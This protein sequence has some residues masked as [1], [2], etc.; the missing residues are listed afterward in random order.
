MR[1]TSNP[2]F[3]NLPTQ[4]GGYATFDRS[5]GG[6]M[7]GA[8]A[9]A[10][11]QSSHVDPS[12]AAQETGRPITVDD[13]VQRTAISGGLALVAGF[14]TMWSGLI[15]LA[16]PAFVVGIVVALIVIFKQK[17]SAPL[18]LTYSGAMGV[19]L[20]GISSM[21]PGVALQAVIGTAGVFFGM[22][23]VYKTGA[24]RVT[25]RFTKWMMGALIGVV[26]LMLANLVMSFFVGGGLGLR[27]GSPLAILFSLVVIGVAAFSLLLDFDAADNAVKAG[28]PEKYSW[29]IAFGLMT[30]LVWLYIE[31]F[32]LLSYFQGD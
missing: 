4:Q 24:V 14:L 5:G 18:T 12:Q 7:G 1:S 20:G 27:D 15:V 22:L 25:P 32:R 2:A 23:V 26:V 11:S 19:A 3:R 8:S 30:T 6:M 28:V 29:Y 16:L 10:G 31:I 17:P 21:Y 13:I 9:Y